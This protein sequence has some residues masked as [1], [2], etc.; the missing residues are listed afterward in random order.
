MTGTF[1]Y[2]AV[3]LFEAV[4]IESPWQKVFSVFGL[5]ASAHFKC[6]ATKK[7]RYGL[8]REFLLYTGEEICRPKSFQLLM[9]KHPS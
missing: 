1:Q 9:Y 7:F 3:K 6:L 8:R 4:L 2:F 5:F